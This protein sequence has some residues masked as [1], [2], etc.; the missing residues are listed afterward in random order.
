MLH[1]NVH[2]SGTPHYTDDDLLT[3]TEAAKFLRLADG[4]LRNWRYAGKGP[5]Y[6]KVGGRIRYCFRNLKAFGESSAEAA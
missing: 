1:D 6:K 3:P 4:T 5:R 2:Q